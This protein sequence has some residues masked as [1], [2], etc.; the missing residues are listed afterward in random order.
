MYHLFSLLLF[1]TTTILTAQN[2]WALEASVGGQLGIFPRDLVRET[3]IGT[4]DPRTRQV[5]LAARLPLD[6]YWALRVG[7]AGQSGNIY[8]SSWENQFQRDER[9]WDYTVRSQYV[10]VA[11]A[12]LKGKRFA[13]RWRYYS[14]SGLALHREVRRRGF[15]FASNAVGNSIFDRLSNPADDRLYPGAFAFLGLTRYLTP[16]LGLTLEPVIRFERHG[17]RDFYPFERGAWQT[18]AGVS[19][20]VEFLGKSLP[21]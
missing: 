12:I 17:L 11:V 2:P 1:I 8:L 20:R 14:G 16:R 4:L 15:V 6:D 7:V 10:R 3:H 13:P 21:F 19:L 5:G 9:S 18:L